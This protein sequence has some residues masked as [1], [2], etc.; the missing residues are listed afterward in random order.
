MKLT[1]FGATGLV[2][3]ECLT[4]CLEAGHEVTLLLR[5]PAKLAD[6]LRSRVQVVEGMVGRGVGLKILILGGTPMALY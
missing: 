6:E 3:R 2:G 5:T 4:Q 1:I